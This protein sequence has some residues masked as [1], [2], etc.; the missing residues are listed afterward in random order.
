MN[1]RLLILGANGMLGA[2]LLRYLTKLDEFEVFGTVRNDEAK[3]NLNDQGFDNL[4]SEID[5][6]DFDTVAS[7][8][9][10]TRP[11][12]VLNC[13]GIIKQ[14]DA[15]KAPIDAVVINSL[16][17]HQ[18]ASEC[19]S[20][21]AKL[22][23]FST[24]CVFSG[25]DGF[26]AE[27]D[28]PDP[29]DIYGR[30]KLLGEVAYGEH[31]TLRTSIIGHE[32]GRALS[33]V[34]WFLSQSKLVW[35]YQNAIFSG[36]PTVCVAEFLVNYVFEK[37]LSGLYHLSSDPIDK[38]SLLSLVNEFYL[39]GNEILPSSELVI[40][41]SLNSSRLSDLTGYI[42]DS[43]PKQIEKMRREYLAYFV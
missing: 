1:N 26:Y 29:V 9:R 6:H 43:W 38:F 3:K 23:H 10:E 4:I 13:V 33:L 15:S 12:Y 8:I 14:L 20:V 2:S 11:A 34:D 32:L 40:D 21:G 28:I 31:L 16:L 41:R 5:A 36:L 18:L 37:N 24:D 30:S 7:T 27:S 17:P 39:S 22:I 42:P 19:D 25:R 35:G